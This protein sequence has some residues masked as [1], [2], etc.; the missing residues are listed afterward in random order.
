M[1][2]GKVNNQNFAYIPFLKL[3]NIIKY[4]AKLHGI[5]TKIVSEHHTSKCSAVDGERICTHSEYV[6]VRA[7]SMVGRKK[8]GVGE[9]KYKPRG[10]FR[11][12]NGYYINSDINAAYNIGRL[13]FPN[14]FNN[15]PLK[16]MLRPPMKIP[17]N[18]IKLYQAKSAL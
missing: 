16:D 13:K 15:I 6:G 10:L 9:K 8:G 1:R 5:N 17:L 2:L 18:V 12:K 7:P 11:T 4:K 14:L 3:I